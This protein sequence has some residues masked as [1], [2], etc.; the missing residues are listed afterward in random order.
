MRD[1]QD[2]FSGDGH[3]GVAFFVISKVF[4]VYAIAIGIFLHGDRLLLLL[5][6][7]MEILIGLAV[8]TALLV[9]SGRF[10]RHGILEKTRLDPDEAE[11]FSEDRV[12]I[13][14]TA[15]SGR[16]TRLVGGFIRLT[17]RRLMI[18]QRGLLSRW[19]VIRYTA[20]RESTFQSV[21]WFRSGVVNFALE[22]VRVEADRVFIVPIDKGFWS[23]YPRFIELHTTRGD[24]ISSHLMVAP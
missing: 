18:C 15:T 24:D 2:R 22:A 3:N 19:H 10:R 4:S 5:S 7:N 23:G 17:N 16:K 9:I 21:S 8:V 6:Q 13:V 11:I 1:N 14:V 12:R 20:H